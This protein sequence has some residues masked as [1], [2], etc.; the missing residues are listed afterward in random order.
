MICVSRDGNQGNL[1]VDTGENWETALPWSIGECVTL[2]LCLAIYRY[3]E[4]YRESGAGS[5]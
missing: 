5:W 4:R 2:V 3:R 1:P